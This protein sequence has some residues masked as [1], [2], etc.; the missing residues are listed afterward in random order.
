MGRVAG[1]ATLQSFGATA[2]ADA[3]AIGLSE[4][5]GDLEEPW[6]RHPGEF[7]EHDRAL[8]NRLKAN[9]PRFSDRLAH[10]LVVGNVID[11]FS[12]PA[13]VLVL[14]N[15]DASLRYEALRPYPALYRFYKRFA[16]RVVVHSTI[17]DR[18]G[19]KWLETGFERG[20][21]RLQF[22]LQAGMLAPLKEQRASTGRPIALDQIMLGQWRSI[23][24]ITLDKFGTTFGLGNIAFTT[25][26]RRAGEALEIDSRMDS[27]PQLIAPP[28][29][30]SLL[31]LL[32]GNFLQGLA[33]GHGGMVVSL[34]S[35]CAARGLFHVRS[36]LSG[37]LRYSPML[38]MLAE[39]G[40][41][42]ADAHD[43]KVREDERRLGE[44]LFNALLEDYNK[45]REQIISL[46][47]PADT[48][49]DP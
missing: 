30:N 37:E 20:R 3:L 38:E 35:G 36:A 22:A 9:A 28:V 13:G 47:T 31:R 17:V 32:A 16:S 25:D 48:D 2:V 41:A 1:E 44:E 49:P 12:T 29:V 8:L 5:Y 23:T 43:V 42:V 11:E 21:I 26:Y 4:I 33:R 7:N 19:N 39:I 45:A 27:V 24:T 40:D 34:Q 46:D 10:Y 14:V 6:D 18:L 15:V